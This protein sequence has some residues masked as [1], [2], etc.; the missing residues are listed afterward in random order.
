MGVGA[1]AAF[2]IGG[3]IGTWQTPKLGAYPEVGAVLLAVLFLAVGLV[4]TLFDRSASGERARFAFVL[5]GV[6]FYVVLSPIS[7]FVLGRIALVPIDVAVWVAL[8]WLYR[9]RVTR[10]PP[11][12]GEG[13]SPVARL[14]P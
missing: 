8:Y 10:T 2:F 6:G 7:E 9:R 12:D 13:S 4:V 5:T 14:E 11:P 1:A 3:Q